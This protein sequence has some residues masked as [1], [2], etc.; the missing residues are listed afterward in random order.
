[1]N[2]STLGSSHTIKYIYQKNIYIKLETVTA[3]ATWNPN[4]ALS[5]LKEIKHGRCKRLD[6]YRS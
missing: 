1:M 4:P 2:M 6:C 5:N 3:E